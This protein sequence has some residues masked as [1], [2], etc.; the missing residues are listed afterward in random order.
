APN[1]KEFSLMFAEGSESPTIADRRAYEPG[2]G[3]VTSLQPDISR[4]VFCSVSET[5]GVIA[6]VI[7]W[8]ALRQSF[9]KRPDHHLAPGISVSTGSAAANATQQHN[10]TKA[11]KPQ[12]RETIIVQPSSDSR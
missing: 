8:A 10:E 6:D 11:R 9:E 4:V 5:I 2:P 1:M 12:D 7:I 3:R